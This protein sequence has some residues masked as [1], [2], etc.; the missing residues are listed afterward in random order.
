MLE[1]KILDAI[2]IVCLNCSG[3]EGDCDTCAVRK[4]VRKSSKTTDIESVYDE[5]VFVDEITGILGEL[6]DKDL[7]DIPE[8]AIVH[9]NEAYNILV[10][11]L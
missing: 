2:D 6:F 9:L 3:V 10:K 8:Q 7:S 5:M 11:E 1:Q 4:M